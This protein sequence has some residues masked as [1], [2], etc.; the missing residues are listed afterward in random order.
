M[1]AILQVRTLYGFHGLSVSLSK[2]THGQHAMK[3]WRQ[4]QKDLKVTPI[5][6][7]AIGGATPLYVERYLYKSIAK[8]VSGLSCVGLVTMFGG[9]R[10]RE[11]DTGQSH[12]NVMASQ[13]MLIPSNYS[14]HWQYSGTVDFAVFYFPDRMAGIQDRLRLL[15]ESRRAPIL[16][17]DAL[18]GATALQIV[19]ELHKGI[20]A[21]EGFMEMLAPVMLEQTYRV[22]TTPAT[23]GINPRHIHFVRLQAVLGYVHE[24]LA[25]DL[26]AQ[27]LADQAQ[28]SLAHFRRLFQEAMGAP[29]HRY[30]LAARLEQAR[31]LLTMTPLPISRIAADCGFSSQSHLTASFRAAHAATP[32]EY[33]EHVKRARIEGSGQSREAAVSR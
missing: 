25:A 30:V 5:V 15:A 24:H 4:V 23:G 3:P 26:S 12:S 14:T 8:S 13:S 31:K 27:V 20:G 9:S 7:G 11:G 21:D 6:E 18:V 1:D 19:N 16:F 10:V 17:G 2:S 29:P 33:R 22:L 32:A 28:V